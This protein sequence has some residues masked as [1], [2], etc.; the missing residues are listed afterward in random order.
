MNAIVLS[1]DQLPSSQW[2]VGQKKNL[3]K[4]IQ[5]CFYQSFLKSGTT[6]NE[7]MEY[8]MLIL[9]WYTIKKGDIQ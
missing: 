1:T 8:H 9:S 6:S 7:Y 2:I 5:A 3:G 4:Q